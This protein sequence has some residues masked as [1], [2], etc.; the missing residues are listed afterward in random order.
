MSMAL[1]NNMIEPVGQRVSLTFAWADYKWPLM[2]L[3]SMSLMGLKFP[4]GYIFVP[5][6]II[7]RFRTDRYDFLIMLIIFFGGYGLIGEN[8]MPVKPWDIGFVVSIIAALLYRKN[9]LIKKTLL[10]ICMYAFCLFVIATFSDESMMVQLRTI[11]NYMCFIYFI[12]PIVVFAGQKFEID[13]FFRHIIVYSVI[14][15]GFYIVD[16]FLIN[17][18]VLLPCTFIWSGAESV[19]YSP[20]IY[21]FGSFPRKYPPGLFIAVLAV[22]PLA[23]CYKLAYWQLI[24]I[25]LAMGA[26]RTFTIITGFI[27]EYF[28]SLSKLKQLLKYVFIILVLG[29]GIYVVDSLLPLKE[30]TEESALRVY[31]S[32]KQILDL[33][34]AVDD[35]DIAEL[36]SGRLGQALPKLELVSEY[37]KTAVG[38]GF[39][40]SELTTDPRYIIDN[41]YYTDVEKSEEVAT[42]IEV[43]PLQVYISSGYVGLVIHVL[44]FVLTYLFIHKFRYSLY[45][46]I[47]LFTL[48]WFGLGGFAQLN[49]HD[50][51]FLCGLAYGIVLLDGFRKEE[52]IMVS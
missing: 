36:G 11:R 32:V 21:N 7:N 12:I 44:F 16:C 9:A 37:G 46:F 26:T 48:F 14:L 8:T 33:R 15:C 20:I 43:E 41:P 27:V 49:A 31:S 45:Y 4:L 28:W 24:L 38:L 25:A 3:L 2:F 6:I 13:I 5:L 23:R 10:L 42:G 40:H 22:F 47:V 51:L 39:L 52:Q 30:D 50:G 19:F 17:G 18:H 35:E 34:E 29:V 1:K